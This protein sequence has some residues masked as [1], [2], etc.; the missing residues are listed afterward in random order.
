MLHGAAVWVLGGSSR[1]QGGASTGGVESSEGGESGEG[2]ESSEGVESGEGG[3]G[4]AFSS[5]ATT[6]R[7]PL[8]SPA[9]A[10][11]KASS[12][13]A[14]DAGAAHTAAARV[15]HPYNAVMHSPL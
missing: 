1:V 11:L 15:A 10:L 8:V 14:M 5:R 6:C 4:S 12:G 3:V 7:P 13:S 2:V 9:Q